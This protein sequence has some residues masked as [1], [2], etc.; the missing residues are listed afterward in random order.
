MIVVQRDVCKVEDLGSHDCHGFRNSIHLTPPVATYIT[1]THLPSSSSH[2]KYMH[3][4]ATS[5]FDPSSIHHNTVAHAAKPECSELGSGP[6]A[7]PIQPTQLHKLSTEPSKASY[8]P[9]L[10]HGLSL[11]YTKD[12]LQH[13]AN[14][15]WPG[16]LCGHRLEVERLF[17]VWV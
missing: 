10:H 5:S 8:L 16:V 17:G 7:D 15:Y 9:R 14:S 2:S 11:R 1:N 3:Y 6:P 12:K 13:V 4:K